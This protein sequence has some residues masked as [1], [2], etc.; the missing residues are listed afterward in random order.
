[1]S[2]AES[3]I[4]W[5]APFQLLA[6]G[7]R[8]RSASRPVSDRDV[9]AFARLTGDRHPQHVDAAWAAASPFGQRIAHGLLVL[10]LA[11]GLTPLDPKRVLAL[12]RVDR[13]VFKR[14]V[15]LGDAIHVHGAIAA[16]QAVDELAGLVTFA[17]RIANQ[18]DALVARADVQV[19]WRGGEA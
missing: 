14:P 9:L 7:Q 6:V 17:W 2:P 10:S 1:M 19:L 16:L 4:A 12:R 8:F 15:R 3:D 13:V 11:V 5:A 18:D